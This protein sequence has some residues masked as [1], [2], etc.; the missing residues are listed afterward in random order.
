MPGLKHTVPPQPRDKGLDGIGAPIPCA[1]IADIDGVVSGIE[2][3]YP[4][5]LDGC[6]DQSKTYVSDEIDLVAIRYGFC[7]M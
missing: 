3:F 7:G 2:E 6:F 1:E 5:T 4:F